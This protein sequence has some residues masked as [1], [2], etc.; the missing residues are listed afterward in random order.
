MD[1]SAPNH[2][3]ISANQRIR[4]HIRGENFIRDSSAH[5]F[6]H[7]PLKS[8]PTNSQMA[9]PPG[10]YS[11]TSTL[12]LVARVSAFSL[13]LAY[14][15]IKLKYLKA[16]REE[17]ILDSESC[18]GEEG[19]LRRWFG[20]KE[21]MVAPPPH[22]EWSVFFCPANSSTSQKKC[23]A[24]DVLCGAF[25]ELPWGQLAAKAKSHQKAEAKAHH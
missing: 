9:P 16:A 13:G 10:P 14:G 4:A 15:S 2:R 18:W 6:L 17:G 21:A 8:Q 12:A 19:E 11:G 1:S 24:I 3:P 20:R 22:S 5:L 23:Q 25:V 7:S